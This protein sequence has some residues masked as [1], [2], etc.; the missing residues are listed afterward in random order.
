ERKKGGRGSTAFM[1]AVA[2]EVGKDSRREIRWLTAIVIV[3]ILLLG[4][5]VYG[6]YWLPSRQGER[7]HGA[8]RT[9]EG[10]PR[11]Q[12]DSVRAGRAVAE[13]VGKDSR[14]KIRWLTAIVIV[15]ILLLGGGVYGVYWLLSRQVE[16]TNEAMR[17]AEDSSRAEGD[18]L[19][20]E[21]TAARAAAAP[22]A[23]VD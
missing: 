4:G 11:A 19:R 14:R 1:R 3:V 8:M 6:G 5:G 15:L 21:L 13:E 23:Q 16:H 2:E 9:A 20:R 10:S 22:A 17:T 18:R 12:G 7:T